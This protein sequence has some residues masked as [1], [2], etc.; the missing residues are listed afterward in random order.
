MAYHPKKR[1]GQ[2]FLRDGDIL[3]Q[4]IEFGELSDSDQVLEI[5]AGDGTLTRALLASGARVTAVELDRDLLPGLTNLAL[6]EPRLEL[7]EGDALKMDHFDLP[8]PMKVISNLPYQ[9]ASGI[10]SDLSPRPD[11]FPMMVLMVQREVG[12]RLAAGPGGKDYGSLTLWVAHRYSVE[13]KRIVPPGSFR[14]PPKVDSAL[15][16]LKALDS[17]RVEVPD[18]EVYFGLIRAAFSMRRKTILN[19]LRSWS[20]P[21]GGPPS[22]GHPGGAQP[23]WLNILNEAEIETRRRAETL[24]AEDFA[25]IARALGP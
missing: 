18:E 2:H 19:N 11:W 10:I 14:P 13:I 8:T 15:I 5:G 25:R 16:L 3:S 20:P 1:L 21:D 6:E 17:P 7:V 12:A 23:D 24:S 9:I 4:I 22:G